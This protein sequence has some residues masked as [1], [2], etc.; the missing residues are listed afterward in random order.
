VNPPR[1][2]CV[3]EWLEGA[4]A[5]VARVLEQLSPEERGTFLKAMAML[6]AEL[7]RP[8]TPTP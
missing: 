2:R 5:P 6:D 4:S 7:S 3:D 1:R 8:S